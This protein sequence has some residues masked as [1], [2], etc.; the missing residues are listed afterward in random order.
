MAIYHMQA[1]VVSR[2]SGRSAVAASAY[3]SCSRIYNDYDG[4]QHDYTRKHG[5]IYQEVMLPPMAPPKWKNRE[6]LWNAVEA[7][8]KTK[9]SRLAREFVVA[10]P[11]ELDKDSNISLLQNFIQKNFVDMGMCADFAIHDTDGHNPHAHILLTVRP[12]NENGTWQYKTE[13]EYLCIKDG[14]E[15]GFTAS[16]FKDAQKEGWEKQYRYK[17]G[18]KKVY[19]TPSA[20][21]EKGYERIDKHPKS[22]RYGRQNPISEQ[23]NSE[24]QLC[25]WRANWADAVNKMLALNQINAAIDHRSFAAQGITEQPT[26]HEGYIAQNME[27]KGMIAD[28]CEI[29][30]RVRAD[31]RILR[32]LKT[33]IKKLVQAVEKSIP[34]I[35]ETLEAIRNHMIFTQYHLLHNEMQKEVIH[36]WMQHFRPILNKYDTIKKKLKAKVTEKKELNVQKSKTSILN[37]FQHIKLNQQLT[38]VTEEIEELKSAK[39][40][41]LFQAECSTEK[42]MASLSRKYDQMD[43]NLDILDSQDMALKEQLEKDAVAFQEEKLRPKPEQYTEL[44]DARIQ[45][46]P[47]FREKLIEQLKGTFGEYYDYHYRDIAANEVDYLN[48]EDPDVFSHR[49]WELEYQRKQELQKKHPVQSRQKSHNT[50]LECLNY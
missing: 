12:L 8:E 15:K 30:R 46:R 27:K 25:L 4:I 18:K 37:P 33:Q 35:A 28:R 32:E 48:V 36:D 44:L 50:E 31:N 21:Q 45:I 5:L 13:K 43:K 11:I 3:M 40:Q 42:D 6:Q 34:V 20:A 10:L 24:E 14:E 16:E 9:D 7:A 26:I 2:G 23:W 47:T 19:L 49:A 41:L 29:N 1:K 17:A 22:T 39:E 38:T